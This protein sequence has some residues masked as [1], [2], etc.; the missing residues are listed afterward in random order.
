MT[1]ADVYRF[2]KEELPGLL[3]RFIVATGGAFT[4][5]TK[6]FLEGEAPLVYRKPFDLFSLR[7]QLKAIVD[8]H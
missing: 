4:P 1:G 3:P 7:R 5:E 2:L 6:D 8:A